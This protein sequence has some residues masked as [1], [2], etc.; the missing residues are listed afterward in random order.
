MEAKKPK[1]KKRR[2]YRKAHLEHFHRN[3]AGEYVYDGPTR[4]WG[5]PRGK[6][7]RLLWLCALVA[8]A[9]AVAG[10]CIPDC[11]M[12]QYPWSLL[13]YGAALLLSFVQL[14]KLWRLTDG[15]DPVRE[16]VWMATVKPLP[17]LSLLTAICAGVAAAAE[18]V[19]LF[20]PDFSGK[21]FAGI[22]YM[23][24][25]VLVFVTS[26]VIRQRILRLEWT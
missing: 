23:L 16:Y 17:V 13:P 11:G 9:A 20:L 2:S 22:F 3:V 14:W 5:S 1:E 19:N 18:L 24:L 10:G 15:G 21:I 26:V 4:S 7:L 8:L 12:E 6:N 25:E